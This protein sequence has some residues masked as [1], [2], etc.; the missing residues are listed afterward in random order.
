MIFFIKDQNNKLYA[1]CKYD[2][3]SKSL[4]LQK[5]SFIKKTFDCAGCDAVN[6]LRNE[7]LDQGKLES[8]NDKVYLL[9]D[10]IEF[11]DI[12]SAVCLVLGG[13]LQNA[14]E[15]IQNEFGESIKEFYTEVFE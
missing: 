3:E 1:K 10:T 12:N 14:E 8:H 2:K 11:K 4:F 15:L 6:R 7:L 9:K 5:S 13:K